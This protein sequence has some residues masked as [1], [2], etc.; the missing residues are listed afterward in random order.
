[1][2]GLEEEAKVFYGTLE[3]NT[4]RVSFRSREYWRRAAERALNLRPDLEIDDEDDTTIGPKFLCEF[5]VERKARM[6]QASYPTDKQDQAGAEA[7]DEYQG[8]NEDPNG[9]ENC[10][11]S[12][13]PDLSWVESS[14][15]TNL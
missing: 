6:A 3:S 10:E 4:T 2:L 1:V 11:V 9:S 8:V 5:E 7:R 15:G 14:S 12:D 13:K